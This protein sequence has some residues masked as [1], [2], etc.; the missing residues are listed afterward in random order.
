MLKGTFEYKGI[1]IATTPTATTVNARV[2]IVYHDMSQKE[3]PTSAA[4]RAAIDEILANTTSYPPDTTTLNMY[5]QAMAD[6]ILDID[7]LS[8]YGISVQLIHDVSN[9]SATYT[10]GGVTSLD[11]PQIA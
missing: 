11:A 9:D 10:K 5:A 2:L 4:V 8:A 7:K 3:L 6:Q 1:S